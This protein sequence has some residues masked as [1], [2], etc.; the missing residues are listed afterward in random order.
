MIPTVEGSRL[1]PKT[2]FSGKVLIILLK[3]KNKD[4]FS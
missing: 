3:K 1:S 2:H 4:M